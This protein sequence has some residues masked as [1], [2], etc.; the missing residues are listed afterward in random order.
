M[1]RLAE[2]SEKV[3]EKLS[4]ETKDFVSLI[5]K[6]ITMD[7]LAQILVKGVRSKDQRCV[8]QNMEKLLR[9]I[10]AYPKEELTALSDSNFQIVMVGG[11]KEDIKTIQGTKEELPMILNPAQKEI[12]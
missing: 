2:V 4:E 11:K 9:I 5:K 7:E 1:R 8:D 6:Y 12:Q 3:A 10:S